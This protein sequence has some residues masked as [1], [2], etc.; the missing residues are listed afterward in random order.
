MNS[1]ELEGMKKLMVVI[2]SNPENRCPICKDEFSLTAC[3]YQPVWS[4][5][6][7]NIVCKDCNEMIGRDTECGF[8]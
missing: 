5:Y 3:N 8:A 7:D 2:N 4:D 6:Y 1:G